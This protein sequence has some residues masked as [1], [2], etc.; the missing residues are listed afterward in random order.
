MNLNVC[1]PTLIAMFKEKYTQTERGMCWI[2]STF[3]NKVKSDSHL[4][5]K[6][7]AVISLWL[8][9]SPTVII[10][11]LFMHSTVLACQWGVCQYT[12]LTNDILNTISTNKIKNKIT[13][14]VEIN[15]L[16]FNSFS[17]C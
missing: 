6:L 7:S 13:K 5:F 14:N 11:L 1:Q 12:Y 4:S 8:A 15:I 3:S 16:N 10:N 2:R 17:S 9:T